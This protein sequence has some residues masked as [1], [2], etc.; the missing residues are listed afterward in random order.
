MTA[1]VTTVADFRGGK[2]RL[3]RNGRI[4]NFVKACHARGIAVL[5]D[6]VHNHYGPSDLEMWELDGWKGV[7][8]IGGGIYF[9]QSNTNLQVTPYGATRPNF[10]SNQVCSFI[11]DNFTLWLNECH[12]DGFRWDTPDLMMHDN[13]GNHIQAADSLIY[14]INQMIHTNYNR[15]DQ[16]FRGC[17]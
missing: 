17:L 4:K 12:V 6:V 5:M 10:S 13:N 14:G 11:Q 2:H 7:G 3:R 9:N 1:G 8:P 16:H 15:Q